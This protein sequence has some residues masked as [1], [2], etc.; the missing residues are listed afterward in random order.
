MN[1][2][3]LVACGILHN[4]VLERSTRESDSYFTSPTSMAP[5]GL[6]YLPTRVEDHEDSDSFL[7]ST[8][9]QT[10]DARNDIVDYINHQ[11]FVRPTYSVKRNSGEVNN[12]DKNVP[13]IQ[14]GKIDYS[15]MF[16]IKRREIIM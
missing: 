8:A 4:F 3:I 5:S 16:L 10:G 13:G 7:E 11:K 1:A 6:E 14:F 2:D 12:N 9:F 15:W